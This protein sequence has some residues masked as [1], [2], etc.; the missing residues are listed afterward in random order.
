MTPNQP[1]KKLYNESGEI[2][3][4]ITKESPFSNN[5]DS[6]RQKRHSV[7]KYIIITNPLTGEFIGKVKTNGNNRKPC[8]R[9][10]KFR[11][12]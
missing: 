4:E 10:G 2:S 3:N 8:Q 11:C 12:S 7:G 5:N 6:N 9:T 1:Y